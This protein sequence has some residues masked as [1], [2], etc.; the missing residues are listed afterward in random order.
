V[1]FGTILRKKVS[2]TDVT[3]KH[4][5]AHRMENAHSYFPVGQKAKLTTA[6]YAQ[7][8][9]WH[10]RNLKP[11]RMHQTHTNT[12][13]TLW[14]WGESPHW[15]IW[16]LNL[17]ISYSVSHLLSH[18]SKHVCLYLS[19]CLLSPF[20]AYKNNKNKSSNLTSTHTY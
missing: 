5:N 4:T 12:N 16:G 1:F 2:N 6:K 20:C 9:N 14:A 18:W 10:C 13:K 17:W 8:S 15:L 7:R 19:V 11:P 3:F